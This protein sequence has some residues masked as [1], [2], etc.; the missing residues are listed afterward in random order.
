[1][2]TPN[3]APTGEADMPRVSV[4]MAT[5][6]RSNIVGYAIESVRAQTFADWE[7]IVVGDAC[8]DDTAA[9][10]DAFGDPRIRFVN[11]GKNTG[12]QSQPNNEGVRL[13]RGALLA[14]LNHDDMWLPDHLTTM[15][16]ALD[17]T[18]ADLVF[19]LVS[20]RQVD[21]LPPLACACPSG[22]F[23]PQVAVPASAWVFQRTLADEVGPWRYYRECVL[24]PSQDWLHRAHRAGRTLVAVAALGVIAIQSGARAR[25]Y[26]DR[27]ETEHRRLAAQLRSDS[28]LLVRELTALAVGH[29]WADPVFGGALAVRPY[30]GRGIKNA[31]RRLAW[32]VGVNPVT[33]RL[34]FRRGVFIDRLRAVRGLPPLGRKET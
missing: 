28:G 7:L 31:I 27:H 14:F 23:E 24:A 19:S 29:G 20:L 5:Y 8:T 16:D 15:V 1:M 21:G 10:V 18:G 26:V 22:R 12:E 34:G 25:S 11:L 33:L 3:D 30:L 2:D 4:I 13:A 17:A 9:V 6:N 32:R